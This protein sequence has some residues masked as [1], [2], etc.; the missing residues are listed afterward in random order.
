M[1]PQHGDQLAYRGSNP[2]GKMSSVSR[3]YHRSNILASLAC[4]RGAATR[5]GAW[6][7]IRRSLGFFVG[8]RPLLV[9]PDSRRL[10]PP[11]CSRLCLKWYCCRSRKSYGRLCKPCCRVCK[12]Y[13][14]VCKPN[15]RL[16]VLHSRPVKS[17]SSTQ[18]LKSFD[19]L[20]RNTYC[21][22]SS[23]SNR[24]VTLDTRPLTSCSP[25]I[26]PSSRVINPHRQYFKSY[27]RSILPCGRNSKH[28]IRPSKPYCSL[29]SI[30]PLRPSTRTVEPFCPPVQSPLRIQHDCLPRTLVSSV[31]QASQSA[32]PL[33]PTSVQDT[34]CQPRPS[35][36]HPPHSATSRPSQSTYRPPLLK[37]EFMS[38]INRP[39]STTHKPQSRTIRPHQSI[40][41]P[42]QSSSLI[43][44]V[45]K[46]PFEATSSPLLLYLLVLMVVF[47]LPGRVRGK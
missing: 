34:T 30:Q 2:A 13:G 35:T 21:H 10:K 14:R 23:V 45:S 26:P 33:R 40:N 18:S 27:S 46:Y 16:T 31:H 20:L 29:P 44:T 42:P 25:G 24:P 43:Q 41:R 6:P 9:P 11:S 19:R 22:P 7:P 17:S 1:T 3:E 15:S 36:S 47:A 8:H 39:Q 4:S 12:L 5:T 37:N 32:S 28:C 38:S